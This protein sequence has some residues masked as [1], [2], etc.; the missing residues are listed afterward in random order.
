MTRTLIEVVVTV[1]VMILALS[2]IFLTGKVSLKKTSEL[3]VPRSFRLD[4]LGTRGNAAVSGGRALIV[5]VM[6]LGPDDLDSS[7][8]LNR[9]KWLVII[10]NSSGEF[11]SHP[12]EIRE[13][14]GHH[15]SSFSRGEVW[16]LICKGLSQERG[17]SYSVKVFGP[18][19]SHGIHISP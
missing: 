18:G 11:S 9:E 13:I 1:I 12:D 3:V 17:K 15:D 19:N 2:V 6:N 14:F 8:A 4:I 10:K 16:T 7:V 5:Y